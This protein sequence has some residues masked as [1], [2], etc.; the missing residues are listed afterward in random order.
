MAASVSFVCLAGTWITEK[1]LVCRLGTYKPESNMT[2]E[3]CAGFI[4]PWGTQSQRAYR[5]NTSGSLYPGFVGCEPDHGKRICQMGAAGTYFCYNADAYGLF[6][7]NYTGCL[8]YCSCLFQCDS[9]YLTLFSNCECFCAEIRLRCGHWHAFFDD[10]AFC[11]CFYIGAYSHATHQD[12][13]WITNGHGRF[14]LLFALA[15]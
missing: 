7:R 11:H 15:D 14:N 9:P 4:R 2:I 10:A 13:G 5:R 8:S 6:A 3:E 12:L 1:I